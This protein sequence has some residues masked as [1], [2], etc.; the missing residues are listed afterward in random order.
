MNLQGKKNLFPCIFATDSQS[1]G[2]IRFMAITTRGGEERKSAKAG[3]RK[4]S[5]KEES[6]PPSHFD[7]LQR[8]SGLDS[9]ECTF[10][11]VN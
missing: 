9:T 10:E 2:V 6:H 4:G 5:S 7:F 3:Q 11:I 1:D 8:F